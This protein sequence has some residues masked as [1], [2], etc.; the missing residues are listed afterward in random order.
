MNRQL[1][2]ELDAA[3]TAVVEDIRRAADELARVLEAERDALASAD[4]AAL[5]RIGSHKQQLM[6][7]LEQYDAERVQLSEALPAA[8][9]LAT[10]WQE[11][12]QTLANCRQLNQRNGSLVAQRLEQVRRALAVLTGQPGDAELYGPSGEL[13]ARPRSQQLAQ[14]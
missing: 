5:D 13:R 10:R 4:A 7:Q 3:L 6:Q 14:A 1:Q 9:L 11:V 8:A 2:T 12:L